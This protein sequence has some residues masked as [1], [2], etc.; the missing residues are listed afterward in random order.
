[1]LDE[2]YLQTAAKEVGLDLDRFN[3]D[4]QGAELA[5]LLDKDIA[6]AK[7]IGVQGTPSL[8]VNGRPLKSRSMPGLY[9]LIDEELTKTKQE[10]PTPTP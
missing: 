6:N 2:Q 3:A 4:R 7:E 5:Q 8:F 10:R 1:M 9:Q